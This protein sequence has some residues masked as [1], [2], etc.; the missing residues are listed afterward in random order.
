M[1][2]SGDN[3]EFKRTSEIKPTLEEEL[4]GNTGEPV[5]FPKPL[6]TAGLAPPKKRQSFLRGRL[7]KL[8]LLQAVAATAGVSALLSGYGI[9]FLGDLFPPDLSGQT[10]D[11]TEEETTGD[12]TTINGGGGVNTGDPE[13]TTSAPGDETTEDETT[14]EI[15]PPETEETSSPDETSEPDE[16]TDGPEETTAPEDTSE[17]HVHTFGALRT[18]LEPTCTEAGEAEQVCSGCG[19]VEKVPVD[20]LGHDVVN[21]QAV[22]ASCT[23]TGLSA[24]THCSR[25]GTV[26]HAQTVLAALGH[27]FG[28]WTTATAATCT[29]DGSEKHTCSRCGLS[30]TQTI[31]ATGHTP[32]TDQPVAAS[33]TAA[34]LTAGSHCSTCGTVIRAQSEIKALGHDFGAWT[35]VNAATCT[36]DG[37]EER[38]CSRCGLKETQTLTAAGHTVVTDQPVAATCTA[39]GLTAGSHCSVCGTVFR[40]QTQTQ[41]LGHNFGAWTTVNAATCTADGLEKHTCSRCGAT[42]TQTI[43]ATGHT[44]VNDAA[45]AATCT[46]TGLSA[47]T[48]C[49][50]CGTVLRAQKTTD[51]LGHDF[52]QWTTVKA[53]T[54]TADGSEKHTCSR[55]GVTETQTVPATGHTVVVDPAEAATCTEPGL[56]EGTHCSVC[57]VVLTSQERTQVLGHN[58]GEW[59]VTTPAS[60]LKEGAKERT[61]SRCG[62]IEYGV[63][64]AAGHTPSTVPKVPATCTEDGFT[65]YTVCSVCGDT[66]ERGSVIPATGHSYDST[67]GIC[68]TCGSSVLSYYYYDNYE[69]MYGSD[70]SLL[71]GTHIEVNSE[72]HPYEIPAGSERMLRLEFDGLESDE[73]YLVGA[74]VEWEVASYGPPLGM[75]N[76]GES[77]MLYLYPDEVLPNEAESFDL[78]ILLTVSGGGNRYTGVRF[79]VRI[80]TD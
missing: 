59:T 63:I 34:G 15:T 30:E 9:D 48:H 8:F 33:C 17:T 19:Y 78:C 11:T 57:G 67:T 40:A 58:Y 32:V 79:Y 50:V 5:T 26:F 51:A 71:P 70:Q 12:E 16:T 7:R 14:E 62:E 22:A 60:C 2:Y 69:Q 10:E 4:R 31:A 49:S 6:K 20:P 3:L 65:A 47:G 56:T 37:S 43:S 64:E 13:V 24:G 53:A 25:C 42:E 74:E 36:A 23:A 21:D 72:D 46:E 52:G 61:C 28:E 75:E 38:T 35:T 68:S 1:Y 29:A 77:K 73:W 18:T 41:A 27:D 39:P 44:V 45:V 76:A 80:Y 55:C 54:C 66:L